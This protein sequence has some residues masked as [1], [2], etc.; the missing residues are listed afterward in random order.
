MKKIILRLDDACEKRNIINW[1]RIEEIFDKY[2]VKP[3]V[4]VIPCCKDPCMDQYKEDKDFWN[5]VQTW[6][7]KDW[8]IAM[9]GF[10]HRYLTSDGGINPVNKRSEFA[11]LPLKIQKEKIRE[12]IRIFAK[13]EIEPKVFFAPSH[14]FDKNTLLALKEESNIRIISDTIAYDSY[15]ENDFM[16]VPQQ[17]GKVRRLPLKTITFCYHPNTMNESDFIE[18]EKKL[19]KINVSQFPSEIVTRKKSFV[20]VILHKIYFLIH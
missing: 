8:T 20:D 2:S 4:G 6:K 15:F 12:G 7:L 19:K 13:H 16:F 17:S 14:T 9:H 3:I 18:L 5:R 1:N 10:D 11:G